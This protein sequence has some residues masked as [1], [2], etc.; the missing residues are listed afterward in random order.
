MKPKSTLPT[1]DRIDGIPLD[2][3][4]R[5]FLARTIEAIYGLDPIRR[6]EAVTEQ[7]IAV[8]RQCSV[9]VDGCW[10]LRKTVDSTRLGT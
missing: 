4:V 10:S 7:A 3:S 6:R 9:N 1:P 2:A 8:T 5:G